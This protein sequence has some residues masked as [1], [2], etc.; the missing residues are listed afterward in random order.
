MNNTRFA[1][2]LDFGTESG[3]ALL[4]EVETGRQVASA[5]YVYAGG[6]MDRSLPGS[7]AAL[8]A[9]WALQDPH[10]YIETLRQAVPEVLRAS[11]VARDAVVGIGVDFTA[12]TVLP[13]RADGTPLCYLDEW[14]AHP[15]A[16]V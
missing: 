13:T 10:D 12:C 8:S 7:S 14:K 5:V 1:L 3:R 4:V 16:W 9:E 15:H 2:G 11:G 6:V